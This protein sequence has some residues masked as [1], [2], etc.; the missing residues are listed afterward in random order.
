MLQVVQASI[1]NITSTVPTAKIL[2]PP[3]RA[4]RR[5]PDGED[6]VPEGLELVRAAYEAA[7]GSCAQPVEM[8]PLARRLGLG[9]RV[10]ENL[11]MRLQAER[12][13]RVVSMANGLLR[14]TPEGVRAAESAASEPPD[15]AAPTGAPRVGGGLAGTRVA[16]ASPVVG[17]GALREL[18]GMLGPLKADLDRLDL[19]GALDE[20]QRSEL[21]AEIRTI[22]AQLGSPRPKRRIVAA[23]LESVRGIVRSAD[24]AA[25]NAESERIL[26]AIDAF[27]EGAGPGARRPE[28]ES[29]AIA[30]AQAAGGV[31]VRK[32][33]RDD[34]GRAT[35]QAQGAF[36]PAGEGANEAVEDVGEGADRAGRGAGGAA[37][38]AGDAADRARAREAEAGRRVLR[39]VDPSGNILR[40]ALNGDGEILDEEVVGNVADS[41]V[42]EYPDEGG[43]VVDRAED[44]PGPPIRPRLGE[45]GGLLDPR[46]PPP[47]GAKETVEESGHESR[48]ESRSQEAKQRT[49][50]RD[51]GDLPARFL[52]QT[53]GGAWDFHG[54]SL[55]RIGGR[56]VPVVF[57]ASGA[58]G[59]TLRSATAAEGRKLN[60]KRPVGDGE[61]ET[62]DQR[63]RT[64][65]Q[66][67]QREKV[68][69]GTQNLQQQSQDEQYLQQAQDFFEQSMSRIKGRMQ[70]DSAQLESIRQQLPEESQA[71]IQEMTDSY[72]Q[73]EGVIDQAAQQARQP[74]DEAAGQ[75]QEAAGGAADQ[76]GQAAQGAQDTAGQAT[77]QAEETADQVAENLPEG[78]QA[79]DES[80]TDEQDNK[81]L[82]GQDEQGNTVT[83]QRGEDKQGNLADSTYDP[84]GNLI[85]Q[86]PVENGS[87]KSGEQP[88]EDSSSSDS[89]TTTV[90]EKKGEE[91]LL[92]GGLLTLDL[93]TTT[94]MATWLGT[95]C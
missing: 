21:A 62:E 22:E 90:E 83:V 11:V 38:R 29:A 2:R 85:S 77:D 49:E 17:R 74:A 70:S 60:K 91:G 4:A 66:R 75:V 58:D 89:N 53:V 94:P 84:Q 25:D 69:E 40:T 18:E 34:G 76:A 47:A 8:R 14:L 54:D 59:D 15:P 43:R 52:R 55:E 28:E 12:L 79:V 45:D 80:T 64:R 13:V 72:A 95:R 48:S 24:G 82:Q 27:L 78:F 87:D 9:R 88:I 93:L 36:W 42:E 46:I 23:A 37:G 3:D 31:R 41:P 10:V 35:G 63:A 67:E 57:L 26:R 1:G 86:A 73:F 44:E 56:R 92:G 61:S 6:L 30:R 16:P 65:E 7:G 5:V 71:Q 39:V 32:R 81:V 33:V 68:S 51:A 20:E 19:D 50:D